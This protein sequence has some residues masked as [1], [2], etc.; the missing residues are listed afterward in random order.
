MEANKEKNYLKVLVVGDS[1][2]RFLPL[3]GALS[4]AISGATIEYMA[5]RYQTDSFTPRVDFDAVVLLIGTNNVERNIENLAGEIKKL[6]DN[7]SNTF[8]Q[9]VKIILGIRHRPKDTN[10]D[11]KEENQLTDKRR[12]INRLLSEMTTNRQDFRYRHPYKIETM[13]MTDLTGHTTRQIDESLYQWDGL[14]FNQRGMERLAL[15]ISTIL[16]DDLRDRLLD[17]KRHKT[18]NY[19][20]INWHGMYIS[21]RIKH[22][23]NRIYF[24]GESSLFSNFRKMTLNIFGEQFHTPESAYQWAKAKFLNYADVAELI[25][26]TTTG[27][28]AKWTA[29]TNINDKDKKLWTRQIS[30]PIMRF[31]QIKRIQQDYHL[32]T[33]MLNNN[34][35]YVEDTSNELWARG[36]N[37]LGENKLGDILT[38]LSHQVKQD[39]TLNLQE[40]ESLHEF[41]YVALTISPNTPRFWRSRMVGEAR[42]D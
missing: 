26:M 18:D 10:W 41:E 36:K 14:H 23:R 8:T 30:I 17:Y 1:M 6:Y 4:I 3:M 20:I 39:Q 32:R 22:I 35:N 42:Q 38:E 28:N 37:H 25:K 34:F 13:M 2:V 7:L 29:D 11:L 15:G 19:K 27:P 40:L 24:K 31:I 12:T 16:Y 9:S 5:R 33:F 21:P